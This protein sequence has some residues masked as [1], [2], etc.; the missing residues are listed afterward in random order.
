MAVDFR[1]IRYGMRVLSGSDAAGVRA[2]NAAAR[3]MD[4]FMRKD[5]CELAASARPS[6]WR[7]RYPK[8]YAKRVWFP[9]TRIVS[10]RNPGATYEP[11]AQPPVRRAVRAELGRV[12]GEVFGR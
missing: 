7:V 6:A 11:H 4:R 2:A 5:T 1:R 9:G 8:D 3:A 10:P 12:A